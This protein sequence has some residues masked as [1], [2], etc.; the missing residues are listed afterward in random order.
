MAAAL[1]LYIRLGLPE[2]WEKLAVDVAEIPLLVYG[3]ATA[4]GAFAIKLAGKSGIHPLAVVAGRERA[5]TQPWKA[6]RALL[7]VKRFSTCS[8]QCKNVAVWRTLAKS[9]RA[10][11]KGVLK[12]VKAGKVSAVKYTFKIEETE[13]EGAY[14]S[15]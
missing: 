6:S 2:P 1:A 10:G 9:S 11:R 5:T 15:Y 3:G 4:V 13:E 7:A 14:K 12:N 8:T